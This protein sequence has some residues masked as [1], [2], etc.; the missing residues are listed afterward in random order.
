MLLLLLL[1]TP[2]CEAIVWANAAADPPVEQVGVMRHAGRL[3]YTR[4]GVCGGSCIWI[5]D[6]WVLTA[7]HGVDS[8]SADSLRVDFPAHDKTRYRVREL[9][10]PK[11]TGI[12]L[13]LLELERPLTHVAPPTLR[14]RPLTAGTSLQL[15]GYGV[16]GPAGSAG[17]GCRFHWGTN[18][19]ESVRKSTARFRLDPVT[20]ATPREALPALFDSGSP[21]F[22]VEGDRPT[23]V[24][25]SIRVS[26][27]SNPTVGD[28]AVMTT[29]DPQ[30]DWIRRLA[31]EVRW[32]E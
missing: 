30:A 5:G 16:H 6:R 12:D 19:V 2:R 22:A 15:G 25:I 28:H 18:S 24:G 27:G 31:P 11:D 1:A 13:A 17:G 29:L 20:N 23:L 21:V 8:W 9:H 3:L 26:H 7:R 14:T 10:L 32:Q 4:W